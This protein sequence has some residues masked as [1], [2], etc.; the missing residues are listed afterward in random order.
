MRTTTRFGASGNSPSVHIEVENRNLEWSP[1][2]MQGMEYANVTVSKD[3]KPGNYKIEPMHAGGSVAATRSSKADFIVG[4]M[5]D[6]KAGAESGER[7][8]SAPMICR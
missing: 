1:D 4:Y 2:A 7:T 6:P 3:C 5:P 8:Q